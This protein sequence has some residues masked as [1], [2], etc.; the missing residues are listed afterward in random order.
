MKNIFKEIEGYEK[1]SK[2]G[3][4][5]N[6]VKNFK[7]LLKREFGSYYADKKTTVVQF[8]NNFR[9]TS[10]S[11]NKD[12]KKDTVP[13]IDVKY[14]EEIE[15]RIGG[16]E[17]S[18]IDQSNNY[19]KS[20]IAQHSPINCSDRKK[21]IQEIS[22]N[23]SCQNDKSYAEKSVISSGSVRNIPSDLARDIPSDSV[24]R[25]SV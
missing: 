23:N 1:W 25:I 14:S 16:M 22:N 9:G 12:V 4:Q 17:M 6:Y 3:N 18:K 11:S 8:L 10:F 5:T 13:K 19:Y 20:N 24:R 21:N 7:W 2:K 15:K